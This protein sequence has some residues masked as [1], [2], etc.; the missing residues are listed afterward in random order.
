MG[1]LI[2]NS[3]YLDFLTKLGIGGA[4]PG[5]INLTKEIFKKETI[6]KSSRILD[7]GCGTGQTAAYLAYKYGA[8]VTGIDISPIMV[9]KAKRRIEKK[10]LAVNI[11]H[12]SVEEIPLPDN[13][14]DFVIS[15]SVLSFANKPRALKEIFR[16]LKTGGRFVAIEQ[17]INY[18]LKEDEETEIKEFYGF[19]SLSTK[20]DWVT[21]FRE[22]GFEHIRIQKNTAI[23]SVPDFHYSEEIAPEIYE[24]MQK[25]F[26][27]IFK[28]QGNLGYR[29][30]TCTK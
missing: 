28:Y 21:F 19:D 11:I 9:A 27:L 12:C 18:P 29:I 7:V 26:E 25:H 17:T 10:R 15:E 5:G 4:H 20:K 23:H 8:Y 14:F 13:D 6:K 3:K 30:Y 16:L 24:I 22:A 2:Q 1:V